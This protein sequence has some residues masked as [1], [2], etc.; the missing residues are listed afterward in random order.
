[1]SR[2]AKLVFVMMLL[3]LLPRPAAAQERTSEKVD[4]I[5]YGTK[6]AEFLIL[7]VGAR[8][9]ALGQAFTAM[10]D[11]ATSLYWN[12]A[13][14]ALMRGPRVHVSHMDYVAGTSYT[15]AGAALPLGGLGTWVVGAQ[16]GGFNFGDQPVYTLEEPDGTGAE[17]SASTFVGGLSLAMN[18][19]DRFSFGGTVKMVQETFQNVSGRT[20]A[21]DVGTN[22]HTEIAGRPF[23]AAFSIL[24]LGGEISLRG[25]DLIRRLPN[26]DPSQPEREDQVELST[27]SFPLPIMFK[28]GVGWEALSTPQNRLTLAGEFWQPQQNNTSTAFGAEYVFSPTGLAGFSLAL[29]G[30]YTYEP[31]R[32]FTL[33]GVNFEDEA[34]DG[35]SFGGG[36][37]YRPSEEGF[38][39]GI[40]YAYRDLGLL[41]SS[42]LFS[43]SIGW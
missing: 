16:V 20:M 9:A 28:V 13:G 11:D 41:G 18:V 37:A 22:Y 24:N 17:Y 34:S 42:G 14:L 38:S 26:P 29:R 15:W 19:T 39:I 23:R 40:D 4:N 31:D 27:Q 21:V 43:I 2:K 5:G 12:P 8:A 35:L 33:N 10:A 36:I 6:A 7:P 32:S 25:S 3:A 1:M 30:G